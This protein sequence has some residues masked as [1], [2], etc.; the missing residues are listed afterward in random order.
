[1]REHGL[2]AALRAFAPGRRLVCPSRVELVAYFDQSL[3]TEAQ[4]AFRAHITAC[5]FC[6]ADLADLAALATPPLFEAAVRLVRD[7][8]KLV[9]HS[10]AAGTPLAPAPVRGATGAALELAAQDEDLELRVRLGNA[11]P[12]AA[13]VRVW[14][15]AKADL[16]RLRVSLLRGDML[17]E[18]RLTGDSDEVLFTGVDVGDYLVCVTPQTGDEAARVELRLEPES[19]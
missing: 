15:R 17:L 12:A 19:N 13:D 10:F 11:G 3:G 1:M 5:P 2:E 4:T 7:G 9:A 16:G 6:A 18:S 14:V 8:L